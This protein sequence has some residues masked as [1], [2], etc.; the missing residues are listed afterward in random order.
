MCNSARTFRFEKQ[1]VNDMG[2]S[3]NTSQGVTDEVKQEVKLL[4]GILLERVNSTR[5]EMVGADSRDA[6]M[7]VDICK[8]ILFD[9]TEELTFHCAEN[10]TMISFMEFQK[11]NFEM[12][13][14]ILPNLVELLSSELNSRSTLV[15][16]NDMLFPSITYYV[17]KKFPNYLMEE[18]YDSLQSMRAS[19]RLMHFLYNWRLIS[20]FLYYCETTLGIALSIKE[21]SELSYDLL[22][23]ILPYETVQPRAYFLSVYDLVAKRDR[24]DLLRWLLDREKPESTDNTNA[25]NWAMAMGAKYGNQRMV[26]TCIERGASDFE[27]AIRN[28]SLGGHVK[29][30]LSIY[31]RRG[32]SLESANDM[33]EC[34]LLAGYDAVVNQALDLGA[35]DFERALEC[36]EYNERREYW[37]RCFKGRIS[38]EEMSE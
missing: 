19:I 15:R 36:L 9:R 13:Q 22:P 31:E 4:E 12:I 11:K 24:M 27:W 8:M 6:G 35:N 7:I 18:N 2:N 29:L 30:A 38:F 25:L 33:M 20:T 23:Y 10:E 1:K 3:N 34:G 37:T 17:M 21:L 32:E 26:D 5:V 28:A 14:K 16:S